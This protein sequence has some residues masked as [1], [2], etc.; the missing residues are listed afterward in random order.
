MRERAR[1]LLAIIAATVVPSGADLARAEESST[2]APPASPCSTAQHREFD[3]W[4]GDW[5]VYTPQ[6]KLAGH[7]RIEREYGGCVLH[8]RYDNGRGYTGESLNTFDASRG[9]W[10]QSWVDS[11]GLLLLLEGGIRD[12]SMVMEGE[13]PGADGRKARQRITWTPGADGGVR[14]LWEAQDA[15]GRWTVV[16]DGR[17]TRRTTAGTAKAGN[18]Q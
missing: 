7:N 16:F 4:L 10:H 5:D 3:F 15:A 2:A 1:T 11:S 17:Y 9:V 12:G 8:E 18:P 14:Q 13:A 6:Q